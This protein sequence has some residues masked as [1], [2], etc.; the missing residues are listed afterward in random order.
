MPE[1]VKPEAGKPGVVLAEAGKP[2]A[3]K[4]GVVLTE[5]GTTKAGTTKAGTTKA[6]TTKAG[7]PKLTNRWLVLALLLGISIFNYGDR[8]LLAGLVD[9]IKQEF[10]VS[11]GFMGLLMGP[12][13]ALLYSLLAVPIAFYADRGSR[14]TIICAGCVI[15]SI[16]TIVSGYASGPY[17]LAGARVG[18]GIGEAA[19]QAPAYS[20]IA[21]YFLPEQRGKAF[22][23]MVLSVYL[24]QILGYRAGPEIAA[25]ADWR[26]AFRIMGSAGLFVVVLAWL[27]I[28]EP[29]RSKQAAESGS[30]LADFKRLF[31]IASY[32]YM[33]IGMGLGVLS[34]AAFGF[35]G[36][37]LFSRVYALTQADA[38]SAFGTAFTLPGMIGALGFGVLADRLT[39]TGYGRALIL[40]AVAL[41][42]ATLSVVAAIWAATIN[43]ATLWAI[44]AGLLGGGWAVGI[45]AGLQ[46]ILPDHMR[47]TGTAIAML[48]VNILGF[49]IGP[50]VAGE[51]SDAFGTGGAGLRWALTLVVP[52][53]IAGALLIWRGAASMEDD[54][55]KLEEKLAEP[56]SASRI[57]T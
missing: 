25:Y 9:P 20:L 10:K 54:R 13:F 1:T 34:G 2:E 21:A 4:P 11:D 36:P 44:P 28:K 15:W 27:I 43:S 17:M 48:L 12:A 52:V 29:K 56:E 50:W 5:A 6:G 41:T 23:I 3:G 45:Y 46:Y 22:A 55:E 33:M 37:A 38:A 18:V 24:G 7:Q 51:L 8:Y 53:G 31:P 49:V 35:W 42:L 39:K 14:I 32:R 40:S 26:L 57:A 30:L 19:F 47:A 16:F